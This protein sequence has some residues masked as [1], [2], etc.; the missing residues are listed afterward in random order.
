MPKTFRMVWRRTADGWRI[1]E[2]TPPFIRIDDTG[3]F[4]FRYQGCRRLS[5]GGLRLLRRVMGR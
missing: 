1:S 5:S 4:R 2:T 3:V